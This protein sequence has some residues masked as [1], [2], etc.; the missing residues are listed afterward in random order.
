MLYM[1]ASQTKLMVYSSKL[2]IISTQMR[3]SGH[4][5]GTESHVL[6]VGGKVDF[7]TSGL[8]IYRKQQ[9]T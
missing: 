5:H 6:V 3:Y 8:Y 1:N 7:I 2:L 4:K 9:K